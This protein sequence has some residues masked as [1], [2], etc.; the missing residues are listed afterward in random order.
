MT[1]LTAPGRAG[2]GEA[3]SA[4]T[5]A[6]NRTVVAACAPEVGDAPLLLLGSRAV[7]SAGPRSDCDLAVVVPSWRVP[8]IVGRLPRAR[9]RAEAV[10][11]V[12]VSLN[13]IPRGRLDRPGQSLYLL[14]V[15]REALVLSSRDGVALRRDAPVDVSAFAKASYALSAVQAVLVAARPG[16]PDDGTLADGIRKAVLLLAQLRLLDRGL[17]EPRL[18]DAV[19]LAA[20]P[21][22]ATLASKADDPGALSMVCQLLADEVERRPLEQAAWRVPARNAQYAGIAALRGR[23]RWRVAV[24]RR[25]VE[26]SLA[27]ALVALLGALGHGVDAVPGEARRWADVAGA[28]SPSWSQAR[29]A[30]VREWR[31]AHPLAGAL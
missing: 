25:S 20:E 30:V 10:T 18:E 16:S 29:D 24:A 17:Y 12:P 5:A 11:G 8:A 13:P 2:A 28:T 19:R 14:K 27:S 4:G 9:R 6:W 26:A 1:V 21:T 7:G 3:S 15:H 23:R 31:D 22:L